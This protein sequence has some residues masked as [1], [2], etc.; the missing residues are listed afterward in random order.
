MREDMRD[1]WSRED[2]PVLISLV[3]EDM[4]DSWSRVRRATHLS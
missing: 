1:S 4:R 3:R 2:S